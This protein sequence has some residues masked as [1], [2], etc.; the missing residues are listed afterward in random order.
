MFN[1]SKPFGSITPPYQPPDCDRPAF[2]EQEGRLYDASHREIIAG[3]PA[4]VEQ[5]APP[6]PAPAPVAA[7]VADAAAAPAPAAAAPAAPKQLTAGDLIANVGSIPWAKWLKEAKRV[8]GKGCPAGKE[9]ILAALAECHSAG[10]AQPK[11]SDEPVKP[12]KGPDGQPIDLKAWGESRTEYLFGEVRK[13]I[14]HSYASVVTNAHD[15]VDVLLREK[16][17]EAKNARNTDNARAPI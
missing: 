3:K 15:A 14:K 17:I 5:P 11:G 8:L 1:K 4:A 9:A 10:G 6:A 13:A 7:P 12:Y 2:F 16:V